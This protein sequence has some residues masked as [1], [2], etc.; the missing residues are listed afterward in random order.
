MTYLIIA[1]NF[2]IAVFGGY[3]IWS[4]CKLRELERK[5]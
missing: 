1:Y 5:Q 3:F 2:A 4:L